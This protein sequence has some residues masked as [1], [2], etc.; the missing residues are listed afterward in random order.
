MRNTLNKYAGRIKQS[1]KSLT[2]R[3]FCS[4]MYIIA[5]SEH[6]PPILSDAVKCVVYII[7]DLALFLCDFPRAK[8]SM[9]TGKDWCVVFVG[10]DGEY[11]EMEN[12]IFQGQEIEMERLSKVLIWRL[13]K[14]TL[15]WLESGVDLVVCK[16]SRFFPWRPTAQYSFSGPDA[17]EQVLDLP[18]SLD[19][20]LV[21]RRIAQNRRRIRKAERQGLRYRFSQSLIDLRFFYNEMYLPSVKRRHA[22]MAKLSSFQDHKCWLKHGGLLLVSQN[23]GPIGGSIIAQSS[24]VCRG[25]EYGILHCDSALMKKGAASLVIWCSLLWAKEQC[26]TQF[27]LGGSDPWCSSGIFQYKSRWGARVER[28]VLNSRPIWIFLSNQLPESLRKRI[29]QIGMVSEL[30][31]KHY[32]VYIPAVNEELRNDKIQEALKRGLEGVAVVQPGFVHA[33]NP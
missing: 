16:L 29:N 7:N 18:D 14:Q 25:I 10:C 26:A 21:G 4:S 33:V 3:I 17:V 23:D 32:R 12:L 15:S 13:P 28:H 19:D 24:K 11:P 2:D 8:A 20:L 9:L 27:D 22:E 5:R 6:L 31:G 30:D 1:I